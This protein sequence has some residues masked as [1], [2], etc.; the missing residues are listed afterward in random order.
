MP[1]WGCFSTQFNLTGIAR[2]KGVEF[3]LRY[4]L[5]PLGAWGRPFQAFANAT[6]LELQGSRQAWFG[7]F[8]PES[9][10]WGLQFKRNPVTAMVKWNYRGQQGAAVAAVNGFEYSKARTTLDVNLEYDVTRSFRCISTPRMSSTSRPSCCAMATRPRSM[11]A[12][13]TLRGTAPS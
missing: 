3:N 8:I 7:G 2:V 11:P 9:A 6:K 12:G 4:S 1:G 5:A 10:N 13:I